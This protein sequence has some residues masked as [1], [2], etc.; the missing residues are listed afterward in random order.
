MPALYLDFDT[1]GQ[2][3]LGGTTLADLGGLLGQDLS[4]MGV[5]PDQ[6][7]FL[8][9]SNIQHIHV[10]NTPAGIVIY[11]NGNPIP[12][13]AWDGESL[14]TTAQTLE[15]LGVG[16]ALLDK[17][18]PL[19]QDLGL[20]IVLRF[21]VAEGTELLPLVDTDSETAAMARAAQEEFLAT[22]VTPP[23]FQLAVDYA[24]DGS[25]TLGDL[26][27][28]EWSQLAPIPWDMLNLSPELIQS[29]SAA[30]VKEIA[31]VTGPA[32]IGLSI[33]GKGLPYIN[34]ADGRVNNMINLAAQLGL[35]E[36]ITGGDPNMMAIVDT[37]ESLLPAVQASN[38]SLRVVFE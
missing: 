33:N 26:S 20:G 22:V 21:P 11:A 6:V 7:A 32:G 12:S 29:A 10:D 3:S 27:R 31:L 2:A 5:S 16:I 38:I 18:L 24:A 17:V 36:G 30:G 9:A 1:D 34:W 37:V 25:W 8:T 23:T 19:V 35:I 13:L 28:E 15:S 14:V 4:N